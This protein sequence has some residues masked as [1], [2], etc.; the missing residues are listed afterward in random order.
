MNHQKIY[1]SIIEKAK[2]ENRSRK[3]GICYEKHHILPKCLNGDDKKEN[4]IL[5]SPREHF[6]C[7]KLLIYMYKN[8]NKIMYAF[9]M[10][11]S[12]KNKKSIYKVSSRDYAYAKEQFRIYLTSEEV[13]EKRRNTIYKRKYS[14]EAIE[15]YIDSLKNTKYS[16]STDP[17]IHISFKN[18]ELNKIDKNKLKE[19]IKYFNEQGCYV[20]TKV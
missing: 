1:E 14:S 15:Q 11:V 3:T 12:I 13:K 20:G 7:H 2:S 9:C 16:P 19:N 10:M 17:V 6:V 18:K 8:N 5:L 4:L